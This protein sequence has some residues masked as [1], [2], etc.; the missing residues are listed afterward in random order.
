MSPRPGARDLTHLL[1]GTSCLSK[2]CPSREP[3]PVSLAR[4]SGRF[5]RSAGL[6]S[7][8]CGSLSFLLFFFTLL[9]RSWIIRVKP[10]LST[11]P[12]TACGPLSQ[13]SMFKH[14]AHSGGERRCLMIGN[15]GV[16]KTELL[17][18]LK[19]GEVVTTIPTIGFNV[20]TVDSPCGV[21]YT[22]WDVG[23]QDKIQP[24]WRHYTSNLSVI[25]FVVDSSAA[26][27]RGAAASAGV[28]SFMD[29]I[30][31]L[32]RFLEA[33]ES[34]LQPGGHPVALLL[35]CNK[36]DLP[37]AVPADVIFGEALPFLP[38]W[39][40]PRSRAVGCSAH[41][42]CIDVL[43][44]LD[45][46]LI[47]G[48]MPMDHK[49]KKQAEEEES[50]AELFSRRL[51]RMVQELHSDR[52]QTPIDDTQ[53]GAAVKC[54]AVVP[55]NSPC[56]SAD[57]DGVDRCRELPYTVVDL[58]VSYLQIADMFPDARWWPTHGRSPCA[59]FVSRAFCA[60]VMTTTSVR[61]VSNE[62]HDQ[63][64]NVSSQSFWRRRAS[65]IVALNV[66]GDMAATYAAMVSL[67]I[68]FLATRGWVKGDE[69][70]E[71][72]C[73]GVPFSG[74]IVHV[75]TQSLTCEDGITPRSP[76]PLRAVAVCGALM[77][78]LYPRDE[79]QSIK[80]ID[81]ELFQRL[82][83]VAMPSIAMQTR[84]SGAEVFGAHSP[85]WALMADAIDAVDVL[86]RYHGL[87]PDTDGRPLVSTVTVALPFG[88]VPATA[89]SIQRLLRRRSFSA[90]NLE[91]NFALPSKVVAALGE[92]IVRGHDGSSRSGGEGDPPFQFLGLKSTRRAT[93]MP[94]MDVLCEALKAPSDDLLGVAISFRTT[95]R[96]SVRDYSVIP[97]PWDDGAMLAELLKVW[98]IVQRDDDRIVFAKSAQAKEKLLENH[99]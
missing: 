41:G 8:R 36:Q 25:M 38:E 49:R 55:R 7:R 5:K 71:N 35:V 76:A 48:T 70:S 15:T 34:E 37:G 9:F 22:I 62:V 6:C 45:G 58:I 21:S 73:L 13:Y 23:G 93:E 61:L 64:T 50:V 52:L 18:K 12:R 1:V 77:C 81:S 33:N 78:L 53:F 39:I 17:Y 94:E 99:F 4:Q 59:M 95:P 47:S 29:D 32:V 16:G 67:L 74:N 85:I 83:L 42:I 60:S 2:P 96:P 26:P 66:P 31:I 30:G 84:G 56:R 44:A 63:H 51:V 46:L 19:L 89:P 79:N 98:E 69:S 88:I 40:R 87:D 57:G 24:L 43:E 65:V 90:L 75:A 86:C 80:V 72:S 27:P 11:Y 68:A 82:L 3:F 10:F 20:E 28:P 54:T 92:L 14:H 97:A 91:M